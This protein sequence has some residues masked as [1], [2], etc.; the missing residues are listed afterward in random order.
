MDFNYGL[1]M[2][3]CG[4][5]VMACSRQK[6]GGGG[7]R[8]HAALRLFIGAANRSRLGR[9]ERDPL[10]IDLFYLHRSYIC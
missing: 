10:E 1:P 9:L 7:F 5:L 8:V 3:L 4:Q 6:F 2:G